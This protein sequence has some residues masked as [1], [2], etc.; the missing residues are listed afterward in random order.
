MDYPEKE[1]CPWCGS[2]EP[3]L[4]EASPVAYAVYCPQCGAIGPHHPEV[5]QSPDQ[6]IR[7]WNN[8]L[9]AATVNPPEPP[10]AAE[11]AYTARWRHLP[12]M[13][14]GLAAVLTLFGIAVDLV[15]GIAGMANGASERHPG[16][17]GDVRDDTPSAYDDPPDPADGDDAI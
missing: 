13:L 4:L 15:I 3:R 14:T 16:L 1:P 12:R 5:A 17:Y 10:G 9:D 2:D 11:K 6:A 7:R 8:E